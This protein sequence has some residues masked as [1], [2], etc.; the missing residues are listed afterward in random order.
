[1]LA[2]FAR[3]LT[4]LLGAGVP[5]MYSLDV[6]CEQFEEDEGRAVFQQIAA[7]VSQGFSLSNALACYPD[8]FSKVVVSMVRTGESMG[9]LT[10]C[11]EKLSLMLERDYQLKERLK[12]AFTYPAFVLG[13]TLLL[14]LFLFYTV[15]PNFVQIFRDMNVPLP[16]LTRV[17]MWITEALRN[18]SCWLIAS[19]V[20]LIGGSRLR[21]LLRTPRGQ[22]A[23]YRLLGRVPVVGSILQYASLARYCWVMETALASGMDLTTCLLLAAG[24]SGHPELEHDAQRVCDSVREGNEISQ[25]YQ[26]YPQHYSR[27]L[28]SMVAAAEESSDLDRT[29]QRLAG[30]FQLEMD[31][32]VD[33]FNALIEPVLMA[34][35]AGIVGT[36]VL[37]VFL[38]LYGF[39]N[40]LGV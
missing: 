9:D 3:Q 24:S 31:E 10:G 2:L 25:H 17:L 36:V 21:A 27:V 8:V 13:T 6:L 39:L 15:L 14:T 33:F 12:G 28:G 1:M 34:L 40:Q 35:V 16:L 20:L 18:P 26:A 19:G 4:V 11:L 7:K 29:F 38:P 23:A 5:L 30:W 32:R 22:L 37:G